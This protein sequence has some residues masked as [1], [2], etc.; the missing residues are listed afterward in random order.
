MRPVGGRGF[1]GEEAVEIGVELSEASMGCESV[2]GYPQEAAG[3][4][5][6]EMHLVVALQLRHLCWV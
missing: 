1:L 6:L 5:V 3:P 2:R 4:S